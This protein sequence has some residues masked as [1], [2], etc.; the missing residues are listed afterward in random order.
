[1]RRNWILW[2]A[3]ALHSS[4]VMALACSPTAS[5][6]TGLAALTE[7]GLSRWPLVALLAVAVG[8]S[9]YDLRWPPEQHWLRV[10]LLLPQ[11]FALAISALGALHAMTAQRFADGVPRDFWFIAADQV[12]YVIAAIFHTAA[13]M[14]V[15]RDS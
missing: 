2:Y 9:V 1:M 14:D 10:S 13:V 7:L 5:G 6:G 11:Q 3:V 12:H 8:C 15:G 4:W